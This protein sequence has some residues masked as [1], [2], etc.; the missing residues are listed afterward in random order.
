MSERAKHWC[1][2]LNNY[3]EEEEAHLKSDFVKEQATYI[4]FGHEFGRN[5]TP[6]LQGYV[7][8]KERK[9]L[10]QAKNIIGRRAHLEVMRGTCAEASEYCKKDDT[11]DYFEYGSLP[12]STSKNG[13]EGAA[14]EYKRLRDWTHEYVAANNSS[15]TE[16]EV[17]NEF[18]MLFIRYKNNVMDFIRTAAP[19]PLNMV[20]E[21][22]E[23]YDWQKDL[24]RLLDAE[25][26]D[27][28]INFI[29]DNEGGKGKSW[30]QR[31]Y[32]QK[33][34]DKV[35]L[36]TPAKRDDIAHALDETK[37]IF[38]FNVPRNGMEYLNFNI[39]EGLKDRVV[40][41]PKYSSRS[42]M[43][44]SNVHVCV[45]CNEMPDMAIMTRDR[46]NI[47]SLSNY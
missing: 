20:D 8:F 13:R 34:F 41:S 14:S 38:F 15:P 39:L 10:N 27:R 42:K 44:A 26:D 1:F 37:S 11:E 28:K 18:P 3:T 40:F 16:R 4:V 47:I 35:Q 45:F 21:S 22:L 19:V 23:L 36:F 32:L 6:H 12:S 29:Y 7:A 30:F 25:A 2:T 33:H 24:E 9:R 46:Y 31:R 17:A 43:W 5:N